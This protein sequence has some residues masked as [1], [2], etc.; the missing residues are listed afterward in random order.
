MRAWIDGQ[1][2]SDA[3]V[4]VADHGFTVGDG[5]FETLK[6]I[7]GRPCAFTRH[8]RRLLHSA[9]G[10][11]LPAPDLESI[12]SGV[13]QLIG[14]HQGIGRLRITFT[15]GVA[16]SGSGRPQQLRPTTVITHVDANPWPDEANVITIDWPRNER[17]PIS[18][19]KTTSYAENVL[20]L[21]RANEAGADEALL[22]NTVGHLCEGTG[23]NVIVRLSGIWV[24]PPLSSGC[25]AGITRELAVER[26]GV[27]ESEIAMDQ[28]ADIE[29]MCLASSTRDLQ[30]VGLI[31]GRRL[32]G[33]GDKA[34]QELQEGFRGIFTES[35]D[36]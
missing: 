3:Q 4:S 15:G 13:D 20:A 29:A 19:L 10:M 33:C 21:A 18:G 7:D 27:L 9:S 31:D 8:M 14:G 22:P 6:T 5:V 12:R 2:V 26:L 36:P 28:L 30:A 23:S 35:L 11:L 1:V 24:T 16:S 25:L 34:T 17:S 32:A